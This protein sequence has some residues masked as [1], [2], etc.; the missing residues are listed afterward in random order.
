MRQVLPIAR[1]AIILH[2]AGRVLLF[3]VSLRWKQATRYALFY[4]NLFPVLAALVDQYGLVHGKAI[5]MLLLCF[6]NYFI[7]G[8]WS[9]RAAILTLVMTLLPCALARPFY[10]NEPVGDTVMTFMGYFGFGVMQMVVITLIATK[11]VMIFVSSEV[12]RSGN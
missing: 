6:V 12:S 1:V 4:E 3:L 9:I 8:F 2:S 7:F 10:F 11:L 5:T